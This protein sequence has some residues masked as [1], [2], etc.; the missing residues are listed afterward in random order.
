M[1]NA[2]KLTALALVCFV[3]ISML[4]SCSK[5]PSN[6]ETFM[7]IAKASGYKVYNIT[8][9][10]SKAEAIK[11][12]TVATPK[13]RSFQIEFYILTDLDSAKKIYAAQGEILDQNQ[14]S[15]LKSSVLNGMNYARRSLRSG[16]RYAVIGYIENTIIYVPPTDEKYKDKIDEFLDKFKY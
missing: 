5:S 12:A 6:T 3:I 1:K 7:S 13:D 2:K 9:Q 11:T 16:G 8:D 15:G 14:G 4:S 10:Y